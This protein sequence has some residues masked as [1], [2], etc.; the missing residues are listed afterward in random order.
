MTDLVVLLVVAAMTAF[1][2]WA[3]S[4]SGGHEAQV[5]GLAT[6][7][8]IAERARDEW[9]A[10]FLEERAQLKQLTVAPPPS[11][12]PIASATEQPLTVGEADRIAV[13]QRR[14]EQARW[15]AGLEP[16]PLTD[17]DASPVN[18]LTTM[19]FTE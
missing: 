16:V 19:E 14:K 1:A 6:R 2:G 8:L 15:L 12:T 3:L 5:N 18:R 11:D 10:L 13:D 7:L 4:R 9:K 17:R